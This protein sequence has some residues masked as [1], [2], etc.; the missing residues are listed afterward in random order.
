MRKILV[1][2]GGAA[3]M[4]A[5]ICA[6]NEN[7][8]VHIFEHNEKLGKKLYITGKGRCNVTNGCEDVEDLFRHVVTNHRFLY[9]AFYTFNNQ[10]MMD[11]LNSLG[12]QLKVE[13]GQRVFP[14]S[15]KSS[16]VI[17]ALSKA[18]KMKHVHV[19]LKMHVDALLA[20]N[21]RVTGIR[22]SDGGTVSADAVILATGGVSYASTGSTGDGHQMA[23]HVG[24]QVTEL[25]PSL[26]PMVVE[27]EW[28]RNLQG[29]SLKNVSF[30]LKQGK[31]VF[32][33]DF[34]EMMF[35]HFGIT[36]PLVLSGS[37]CIAGYLKKGEV[38]AIIDLKPSL[39]E[40][41]LD[42]RLLR[43]FDK[44]INRQLRNSLSELLPSS[45]IPVI[46]ELAGIDPYQVVHDITKEQR[47]QMVQV[48]K[49]LTMTVSGV[50]GFN[51][52]IITQGGIRVKEVDPAT[53]ASKLVEGL[54]FAGEILD[55]DAMTGGYN[56]QIAWSTA[57]MAGKAAAEPSLT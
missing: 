26:V 2:G 6:A 3:G 7:N 22:L 33:K 44:N 30:S 41:Q 57:Y 45:L 49:H 28:C 53:M 50:R 54:Y 35:T 47:Q 11:Y 32:Y 56:L 23:E 43:D 8:E 29:L 27:E 17:Q 1:I 36:G 5:A 19:H 9:S 31:K 46:I 51:E 55:L 15:D 52:A 42:A 37:T 38:K 12:L 18:L 34:G 25:R 10:N 40:E 13:R 14:V 48:I 16:D 4:F 21:G 24:H 20:E 39:S